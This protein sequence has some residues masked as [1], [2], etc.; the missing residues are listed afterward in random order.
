MP[1]IARTSVARLGTAIGFALAIT[2]PAGRTVA[3]RPDSADQDAYVAALTRAIAA[4]ERALDVNEPPR[5]EEALRLFQEAAALRSTRECTY[6]IGVAAEHLSRTD[7]AVEA[8]ETALDLGLVGPA[9]TRAQAF[10]GKHASAMARLT[11]RGPAGRLINVAGVQ[12]GRLPLP[13]P[14]VL[15]PGD[16]RL[17]VAGPS[18]VSDSFTVRLRV[19][20]LDELNL[21]RP[22]QAPPQPAA[23]GTPPPA[24]SVPQPAATPPIALAPSPAPPIPIT[25]APTGPP[26]GPDTP[27]EPETTAS[28]R[29][30]WIAGIGA[31]VAIAAAILLP[32]SSSQIDTNRGKLMGECATV[33]MN[34]TCM[35]IVGHGPAAQSYADSIAT[36]KAIRTGAYV[37]VGVGLA[38]VAG[39]LLLRWHDGSETPAA[40]PALVLDGQG[41]QLQVGLMWARSF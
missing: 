1:L 14:L 35:A 17:D 33:V 2:A 41:G 3:A 6:E 11:V 22:A 7:L 20:Q 5:W 27:V 10:V 34:D 18:G 37:G 38:A 24:V 26:P 40:R 9:R 32:V 36:W 8:Y 25:Q 12:R 30:V 19:G 39:G 28:S 15:F 21:D 13:R 29:G 16:V 31:T 4:K 23:A